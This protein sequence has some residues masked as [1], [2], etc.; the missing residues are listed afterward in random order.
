[1]SFMSFMSCRIG[2]LEANG[3]PDRVAGRDVAALA[4]IH[5]S[6]PEGLPRPAHNLETPKGP[7]C[8]FS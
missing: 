3:T 8:S 2:S 7:S 1:M 4:Q 5:P 6:P